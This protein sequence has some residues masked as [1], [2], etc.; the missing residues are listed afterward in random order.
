MWLVFGV[1]WRSGV[2]SLFVF[3]SAGP[4]VDV[5]SLFGAGDASPTCFVRAVRRFAATRLANFDVPISIPSI[6][7][8]LF[9][10]SMC[11][12]CG[13]SFNSYQKLSVHRKVKHGLRDPINALVDS[14]VC[15]VC[16]VYSI[17]MTGFVF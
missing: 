9:V 11:P 17:F 4:C 14:V 5:P 8:P 7:P 1:A 10:N 12:D 16:L 15:P 2:V 13:K 6:A 3:F